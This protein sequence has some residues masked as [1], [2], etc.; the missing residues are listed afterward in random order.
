MI[1]SLRQIDTLTARMDS[2]L[3][4]VVRRELLNHRALQILVVSAEEKL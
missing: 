3:D 4:Q 1:F 2:L